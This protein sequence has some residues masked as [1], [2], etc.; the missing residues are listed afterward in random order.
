VS[1][2][3]RSLY[4]ILQEH[5]EREVVAE[6][7]IWTHNPPATKEQYYYRKVFEDVYANCGDVVPHM[8]MPRYVDAKDASARTLAI[9]DE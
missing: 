8:W 5:A 1:A 2:T 9:Y 7:C 6:E 4:E 3:A